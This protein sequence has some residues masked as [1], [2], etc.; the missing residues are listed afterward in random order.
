VDAGTGEGVGVHV[1]QVGLGSKDDRRRLPCGDG[2]GFFAWYYEPTLS[3]CRRRRQVGT[4]DQGVLIC[5]T[6]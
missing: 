4:A 3:P 5:D 2:S 6:Y 1:V